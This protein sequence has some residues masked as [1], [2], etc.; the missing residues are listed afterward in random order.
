[1]MLQPVNDNESD[2][3]FTAYELTKLQPVLRPL[4][5]HALEVAKGDEIKAGVLLLGAAEILGIEVLDDDPEP[6][7]AA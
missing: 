7:E 3:L 1:M 4:V 5:Q 2:Y 6:P